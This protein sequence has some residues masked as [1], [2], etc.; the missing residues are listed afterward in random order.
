LKIVTANFPVTIVQLQKLWK[1]YFGTS[2]FNYNFLDEIFERQY[3]ASNQFGNIFAVFS[4]VAIVIACFGLLGLI[5]FS[6][7]Q[8][9]KEIGI[10]KVLGATV[11]TIVVILS[12]DFLKLLVIAFIISIPVSWLVMHQWLLDYA[13]RINI[14]WWIFA[15]AGFSA[16][17]IALT[18]ISLKTINAARMN[19][20]KSL[21]SE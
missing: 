5:A 6:I 4:I 17:L 21:R 8:R 15:V 11:K 3:K 9:T 14:T 13:Y 19:P 7:T 18:T 1:K 10:R 12:K 20:V 16:G 2:P